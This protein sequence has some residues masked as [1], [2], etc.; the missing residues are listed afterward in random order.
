MTTKSRIEWTEHT[1]NPVT[2]CTNVSPGCKH[3]YARVFAERL[4]AMGVA[5]YE[6]GFA[7]T[8]QPDRLNEP[9]ERRRPTVYFVNSMSDLFHD[10]VPF[11][12]VERV[13]DVIR[14]TPH[15]RYQIL[16]KRPERMAIF[17]KARKV[18]SNAWIGVSVENRKH[19]VPRVGQLRRIDAGI[20]F[21]SVEPLLECLGQI[22]LSGIDWVIVGGES[23][24]G[25]RPMKPEWVREIRDQCH[26]A[27]VAFFFKQWGT[28]GPD[29]KRRSKKANGRMLDGNIWNEFPENRL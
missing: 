2:G 7:V 23:G 24:S 29:G 28:W 1:W 18:P 20:R 27:S 17:Y 25:A 12:Y 13:M 26:G 11:A 21:L 22:D 8:L 16:T 5:G 3:C 15:H 14:R 19:G 4:R 10:L 6:N 9:L